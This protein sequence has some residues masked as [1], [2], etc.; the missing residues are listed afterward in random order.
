MQL[1]HRNCPCLKIIGVFFF[2]IFISD[3]PISYS[4]NVPEAELR[5]NEEE[6][7]NF[8]HRQQVDEDIG[9]IREEL[10]QIKKK[11][12][13][14]E[15][16]KSFIG[17]LLKM[18]AGVEKQLSLPE[19]PTVNLKDVVLRLQSD[20]I[21]LSA[22]VELLDKDIRG[23][24]DVLL[25]GFASDEPSESIEA[26]NKVT[27]DTQIT[28][29]NFDVNLESEEEV[30]G[31]YNTAKEN[32]DQGEY[33]VAVSM[34]DELYKRYPKSHYAQSGRFW[35]AEAR[36]KL[37][38]NKNRLEVLNILTALQRELPKDHNKRCDVALLIGRIHLKQMSCDKA[39]PQFKEAEEVCPTQSR[40][41]AQERLKLC[42][43]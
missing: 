19:D 9:E 4:Q 23:S 7:V 20:L 26:E 35:S 6:V 24:L 10:D 2:L 1:R 36:Y 40:L 21:Q 43:E 33:V 18:I 16:T 15:D 31:F 27:T 28:N 38:E 3:S 22:K 39:V 30:A 5:K 29:S 41:K 11:L 25:E 17:E 34:F 13:E 8:Y 37:D 12:S 42:A 14:F 32:F